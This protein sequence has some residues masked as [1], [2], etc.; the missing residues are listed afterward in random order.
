MEG[1]AETPR[2]GQNPC[3]EKT[4]RVS[5]RCVRPIVSLRCVALDCMQLI[6]NGEPSLIEGDRVRHDVGS[7]SKPV[8]HISRPKTVMVWPDGHLDR[9]MS[10]MRY[11]TAP[12]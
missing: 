5:L 11:A 8:L 9:N 10:D 4:T 3:G 2:A 1:A 6:R 7:L 12:Q